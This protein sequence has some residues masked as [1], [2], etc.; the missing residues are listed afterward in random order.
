MSKRKAKE[1]PQREPKPV[2]EVLERFATVYTR[3]W[4]CGVTNL[5][6]WPGLQIHHAARGADREKAREEECCMIRACQQCHSQLLDSMNPARQ[7]ALIRMNN[8][9]AYDRIRFNRLRGGAQIM[10][11]RNVDNAIDEQQVLEE[12]MLL[13]EMAKSNPYP[14]YPYPWWSNN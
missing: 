3:C 8:P 12:Q 11:G 1:K 5:N 6:C 9:A 10:L 4:L 14:N 7:L 2:S 13:E